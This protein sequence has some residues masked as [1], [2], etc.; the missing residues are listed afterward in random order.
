LSLR[1][2]ESTIKHQKEPQHGALFDAYLD[3][4]DALASYLAQRLIEPT[5]VDDILQDLVSIAIEGK[6][7]SDIKSPKSYLFIV[8]RNLMTKHLKRQT[9]AIQREIDD[10][11]LSNIPSNE[12]PVE[13]QV[14]SKAALEA[15]LRHIQHLPRQCRKVFL[16][17]KL[18]G[19]PHKKIA[20]HLNISSSTVER[21]ITNALTRL[22]KQRLA[23]SSPTPQTSQLKNWF[24]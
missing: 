5:D 1:V 19:W 15:T 4:R 24:K 10:L 16:L 22:D 2:E 14:E 6:E 20:S 13:R 21:H 8:A 12:A 7:R 9:L 18:L 3:H 11:D 23:N 17:R